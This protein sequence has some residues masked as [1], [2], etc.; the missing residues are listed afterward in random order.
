MVKC[1]TTIEITTISYNIWLILKLQ[2]FVTELLQVG[3]SD[4]REINYSHLVKKK[5]KIQTHKKLDITETHTMQYNYKI[6]VL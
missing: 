6:L 3:L 4:S 2:D 5:K 1:K